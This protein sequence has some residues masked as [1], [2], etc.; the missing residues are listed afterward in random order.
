MNDDDIDGLIQ[1]ITPIL[2]ARRQPFGI[3][4]CLLKRRFEHYL[5]Y[6]WVPRAVCRELVMTSEGRCG[7]AP[8]AS[9]PMIEDFWDEKPVYLV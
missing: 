3:M 2:R 8:A 9:S 7:A 1:Y 6:K 4:A 5:L